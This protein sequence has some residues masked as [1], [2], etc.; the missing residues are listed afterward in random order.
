MALRTKIECKE[1]PHPGAAVIKTTPPHWRKLKIQLT[2]W[3][4]EKMHGN[5]VQ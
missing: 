1:W 2:R 4:E 3:A 5:I